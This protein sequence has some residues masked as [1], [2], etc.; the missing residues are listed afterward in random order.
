MIKRGMVRCLVYGSSAARLEYAITDDD[1]RTKP[2]DAVYAKPIIDLGLYCE[3][4]DTVIEFDT[5]GLSGLDW[6]V[7]VYDAGITFLTILHDIKYIGIGYDDGVT[8]VA[9]VEAAIA[10]LAGADDIF[11]TKTSGTGAN[12]LSNPDDSR[13]AVD[14][15]NG[16]TPQITVYDSA[17]TEQVSSTD[18]T[19]SD[20]AEVGYLRYEG[21]TA[22]F[23]I[24]ATLTGGTS[25]ATARIVGDDRSGATGTLRIMHVDGTFVDG[26]TIT[27]S[28]SGSA[29]ADGGVTTGV[30]YYDLDISD[31]DTWDVGTGHHALIEY[32]VDSRSYE[33]WI[34]FDIAFSPMA[35]PLITSADV[36]ELRPVYAA[37]KPRSWPDWG[38]AIRKAHG[39]L[40]ARIQAHDEH[41]SQ[42]VRREEEFWRISWAFTEAEIAR[43][44]GFDTEERDRIEKAAEAAWQSRG[45]L[46]TDDDDDSEID[47]TEKA[48]IES[49]LQR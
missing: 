31:T 3:N 43:A 12:V 44:C 20:D 36:D 46:T 11:S 23:S 32:T 26:E 14:F 37:H 35:T 39:D 7:A 33:R 15:Y 48:S 21:Q 45:M 22:E 9:D 4:L 24:G 30:Y 41:A 27:D 28:E 49:R 17:G 8:T 19:E 10:A 38:P 29:T 42:Y 13:A 34:Y 18:M 1:G 6:Q 25:D 47:N 40:V 5:A 2:I 16:A